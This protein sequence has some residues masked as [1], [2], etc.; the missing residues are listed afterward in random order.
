MK[1]TLFDYKQLPF[2]FDEKLLI[3]DMQV[4]LQQNWAAHFNKADY[5]GEWEI[6]ALRSQSG[7]EN[8]IQA[9]SNRGYSNTTLMDK[10]LYF[11][12][13]V[14]SFACEKEAV[15]LMNLKPKSEI[16]THTDMAGGYDDGFCRIHIPIL[17]NQNVQFVVNGQSLPM[18]PGQAWYANFSKPHFIK[19]EGKTDRVHLV[20]DCIRNS[21]TD[22]L[23]E[24]LGYDFEAEKI[25]EHDDETKK[26]MIENLKRI[27]S[28]AA[29]QLI[30]NL[31]KK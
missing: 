14:D 12:Q 1:K 10:C 24:T 28:P 19:N 9:F 27:N 20:V 23:F 29:L 21:W 13:I 26:M 2:E 8:D 18:K 22:A 31:Q 4:C 15:R 17:T 6:I 11:K 16:K 5:A 25:I 30:E 3:A 7:L